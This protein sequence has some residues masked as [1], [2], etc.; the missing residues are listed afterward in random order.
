MFSDGLM[1]DDE[2]HGATD[3]AAVVTAFVKAGVR[4][5]TMAVALTS[6]RCALSVKTDPD[7]K[8]ADCSDA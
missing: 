4:R 3:V 5:N 7:G 8:R 6:V 1:C 2:R